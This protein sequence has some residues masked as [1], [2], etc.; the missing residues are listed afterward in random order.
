MN[1][2]ITLIAIFICLKLF[3]ATVKVSKGTYLNLYYIGFY[4]IEI[5]IACLITLDDPTRELSD[6][7]KLEP[8]IPF[9]DIAT[10]VACI[11]IYC[12]QKSACRFKCQDNT[13]IGE[14]VEYIISRYN[15]TLVSVFF[16]I[17]F[18]LTILKSLNLGYFVSA[19]ALS[20]SFTPS[21]IGLF[22]TRLPK[23][24]KIFWCLSLTVNF[25]FHAMQGSRGTAIF[26]VAF[27]VLGY[28]IYISKDVALL[29]KRILMF[30]FIGFLCLPCMTFIEDFRLNMGRGLD[31][32]MDNLK[33]LL[34]YRSEYND[35][36]AD[37]HKI[38]N[39]VS[40]LMIQANPATVYLTPD[41]VP[42]RYFDSMDSEIKSIFH[43]G[44]EDGGERYNSIRGGL[45]YGTGVAN[46]YGFHVNEYNSVEWPIFADAFSRF[47]YIG[48]FIYS[49]LFALFLAYL[50]QRCKRIWYKNPLLSMSLLF[51]VLY[52]GC[53]S[54]MYSYYS[55][56]KLLIFRM[57]FV[58]FTV[59]IIS[60]ISIRKR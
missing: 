28:L 36:P 6:I 43:F 32:S 10:V 27:F 11:A 1:L 21:F 45:G 33:L 39:S 25:I 22:W 5:A 15:I 30:S 48:I 59:Y 37:D 60:K 47:G 41:I 42:Y 19:F 9:L 20:F 7:V 31:V 44:G 16:L 35:E 58:F 17:G 12:A 4:I 49:Y 23:L 26:P 50:E 54:Y 53:L 24:H 51:F 18:S 2:L 38:A 56:M 46:H 29:K 13:R 14:K 40:R 3:R 57:A 34:N 55:F 8:T 52:N